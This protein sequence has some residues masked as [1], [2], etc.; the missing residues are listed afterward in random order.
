MGLKVDIGK[1]SSGRREIGQP[2]NVCT[3][4]SELLLNEGRTLYINNF[5]ISYE[6][7]KSLLEKKTHVV[8][9]LQ[10]NTINISMEILQAKLKKGE[11]ISRENENGIDVMKWK[12]TR[13]VR[14][15]PTKHAPTLVP[16]PNKRSHTSRILS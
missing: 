9:T 12:D 13:D 10:A 4:L 7:A 8:G 14:I 5:Y 16:L 2:K 15:L 1:S 6:L 3:E 11:M